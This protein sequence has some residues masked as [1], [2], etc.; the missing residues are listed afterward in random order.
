MAGDRLEAVA[1]HG[2]VGNIVDER[3]QIG[4]DHVSALE[5]STRIGNHSL[6]RVEA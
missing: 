2:P 1:L 3:Q 5:M 6:G 4:V